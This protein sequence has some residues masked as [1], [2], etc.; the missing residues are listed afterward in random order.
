[1]GTLELA[2]VG[3]TG[4]G[5]GAVL[6]V[7]LVWRAARRSRDS[8]LV[9]IG[10][11]LLGLSVVAAIISARLL[12]LLP[13]TPGVNHSINLVGLCSYPFLYL[14]VR[15][16]AGRPLTARQGWWLWLPGAL[17]AVFIAA[18]A[19]AG[20]DTRVPFLWL[21]PVMLAFTG[22]CAWAARWRDVP[23]GD[24]TVLSG[25]WIVVF[26]AVLNLAQIVRMLFGNVPLV[27]ALIPAVVTAGFMGLVGLIAW[28]T[29]EQAT[30]PRAP[31]SDARYS[32]STIDRASAERLLAAIDRALSVD[33]LFADPDLTLSR[34]A[35]VVEST[36]HH[37]SEVLNR[38][39]RVTFHDLLSRRRVEDV[40]A[41]LL[42]PANAKYTIEG[43]GASA[44]FGSRSALYG[45]FRR[46]EGMTPTEFRRRHSS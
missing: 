9:L 38:H 25:R 26:F 15:A 23:S 20:A 46:L 13:A 39:G 22:L 21:L 30:P 40:K 18:L 43:I 5:V 37:V 33:R 35:A 17:Y 41:Q 8:R 34:L 42:E 14:Y 36:S 4:S 19:A 44:G 1:M 12:G 27:P 6:G 7:P 2:V 28:R 24:P 3:L 45:A 29:V 31:D 10:T 11:G 16:D 32:K